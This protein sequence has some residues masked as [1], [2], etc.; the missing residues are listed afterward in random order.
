MP[1]DILK[2]STNMT[3]E[4]GASGGYVTGGPIKSDEFVRELNGYAA[5]KKYREM[6]DNDPVI[7]AVFSAIEMTLRSVD[8]HVSEPDT[9][10][11]EEAK[12]F[13]E[14]VLKD[15]DHTF[16]DFLSDTLSMLT[17]GFS[18]IE[19]VMK[20]RNGRKSDPNKTSDY[21]D[22]KIGIHKLAPRAQWTINRFDVDDNGR[23][24]GVEQTALTRRVSTV[25]IPANKLLLFRTSSASNDPSGRSILRNAYKSYHFSSI[26]QEYEAI[27]IERELNGLPVARVPQDYLAADSGP[28]YNFVQA[29][30]TGLRNVKRNE[31]SY[32]LLPSD[33]FRDADGK[34]TTNRLVEFDLLSSNGSRDIDTNKIVLRHQ[35]NIAMSMMA[36]FIMLGSSEKGSYSLSKNLSD[37]FF[38]AIASFLDSIAAVINKDL[39]P[40]LWVVNGFD[41]E[42][43]PTLNPG[44]PDPVDLKELGEFI[45]RLAGSGAPLFPD[46]ELENHIR[47]AAGLPDRPVDMPTVDD[48]EDLLG[49]KRAPLPRRAQPD[50]GD[51]ETGEGDPSLVADE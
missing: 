46:D 18:I 5:I 40:R 27:A 3:R 35:Q 43:M 22:G 50:N 15:M 33:P 29:L 36:S 1:E 2:A 51:M 31:Q 30:K 13:L 17:Y 20:K 6:R 32:L 39:I 25:Y 10:N 11:G 8:W 41:F 47:S 34:P 42:D 49:L 48:P 12:A 7:G 28:K 38:N 37:L 44:A 26:I 45:Q 24:I 9:P 14:E 23:V 16:D 19:I 21:D 4:I